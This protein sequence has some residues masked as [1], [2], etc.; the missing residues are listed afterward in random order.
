M[1]LDEVDT[2][3]A[4]T[5]TTTEEPTV[6]ITGVVEGLQ[7]ELSALQ[8][9]YAI[10]LD[11][12][13]LLTSQQEIIA[14]NHVVERSEHEKIAAADQQLLAVQLHTYK[15]LLA[16]EQAAAKIA[17]AVR[18]DL[19]MTLGALHAEN[20]VLM[21]VVVEEKAV[22]EKKEQE[23]INMTQ[24]IVSIWCPGYEDFRSVVREK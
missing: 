9:N 18:L 20:L 6:I 16:Q 11:N 24:R 2:L 8:S 12:F 14:Q 13:T 17:E 3:I 23:L 1:I 21:S 15:D 4:E 19:Q 7:L 5:H 22:C 10:L